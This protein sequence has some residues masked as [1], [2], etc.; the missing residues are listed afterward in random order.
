MYVNVIFGDINLY[1]PYSETSDIE[2][3]RN[4]EEASGDES[5]KLPD[6]DGCG[7]VGLLGCFLEKNIVMGSCSFAHF[8][9]LMISL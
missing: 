1:I 9:S 3:S 5:D 8:I 7:C 2:S 6:V 4:V